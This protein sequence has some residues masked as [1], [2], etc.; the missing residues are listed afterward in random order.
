MS[1]S[2]VIIIKDKEVE[3]KEARARVGNR[4][5]DYNVADYYD[6]DDSTWT[7]SGDKTV[8]TLKEF[9]ETYEDDFGG[10]SPVSF[11][12][13]RG[14][15]YYSYIDESIIASEFYEFYDQRYEREELLLLYKEI[16][17]K[18]IIKIVKSLLEENS[19]FEVISMDYHF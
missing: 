9:L 2:M 7:V 6:D 15:D 11:F 13:V 12:V 4:L 16:F 1:H 14:E 10:C 18:Q 8:A 3:V 19:N 5:V 17:H